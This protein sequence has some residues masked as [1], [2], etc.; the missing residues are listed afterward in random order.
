[1]SSNIINQ[2]LSLDKTIVQELL[3]EYKII[4]KE[5][6]TED[7]V[8]CLVH[9]GRFA[10]LTIALLTVIYN[11]QSINMNTIHFDALFQQLTAKQKP[12]AEDEI[13]LLAVPYA[14]KTVYTIRNKKKVVHIK[15]INPDFLDGTVSVSI[16]DWILSQIIMLKCNSNPKEVGDFIRSVIEKKIP[17]IEEFEDGSMLVL[18]PNIA[19]RNELLLVLYKVSK[20]L[21]KDELKKVIKIGYPQKLNTTLSVLE[22]KR[23]IHVNDDGIKISQNGIREAEKI[24]LDT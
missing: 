8:N 17:L 23:L 6:F 7:W 13:L 20:R 9:C 16:C 10:E 21:T 22:K 19:F 3:E 24:I 18:N 14:A 5:S 1:M 12:N 15:A 4:K 2:L 11:K